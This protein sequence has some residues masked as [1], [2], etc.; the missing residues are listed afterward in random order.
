MSESFR[1]KETLSQLYHNEGLT[2]T[3]IAGE[4]DCSVS[5]ISNWMRKLNV[6]R[7]ETGPETLECDYCSETFDRW[8]ANITDS[9][10]NFCS[11]KCSGNWK[12][13]NTAKGENHREWSGGKDVFTCDHCGEEYEQYSFHV[14]GKNNYC[15]YDCSGKSNRIEGDPYYGP[16]WKEVRKKA[17]EKCDGSCNYDGCERTETQD[18]RSLH[19][20]HL[21]PLRTFDSYKEA[22]KLPNLVALCAEHHRKIETND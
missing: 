14:R 4:L 20:H 21:T 11:Q 5:T 8:T 16:N 7:K 3:E 15:S 12:R 17:I 19:V 9:N 1:D 10:L 22:N 18:G 6:D 2:Q 13:E